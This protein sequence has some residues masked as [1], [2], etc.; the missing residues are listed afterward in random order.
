ML[1]KNMDLIYFGREMKML[2][3]K[4][5][6]IEILKTKKLQYLKQK[7]HWIGQTINRI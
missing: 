6:Q 3:R 5:S 7:V 4:K 1:E 2:G